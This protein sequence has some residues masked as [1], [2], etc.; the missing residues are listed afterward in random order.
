MFIVKTRP[1]TTPNV[2]FVEPANTLKYVYKKFS[3]E[4]SSVRMLE[5][6]SSKRL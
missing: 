3:A 5:E 1:I 4:I 6:S 2:S